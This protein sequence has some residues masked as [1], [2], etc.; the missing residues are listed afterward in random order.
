MGNRGWGYWTEAKLDILSK[1]LNAFTTASKSAGKTVYLDLFAGS[2]V[3]GFEA[4]SRGAVPVLEHPEFL[5]PPLEH[6]VNC[7]VFHGRDELVKTFEQIFQLSQEQIGRL[8]QGAY[9][10]YQKHLTPGAFARRLLALP[11]GRI[12]LLLNSYRAR[13]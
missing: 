1:Y 9:T 10:Y 7:L 5:D 12:D 4:L 8:R 11:P 6:N 3:L 2:G 13:R